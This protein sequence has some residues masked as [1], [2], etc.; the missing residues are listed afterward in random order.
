MDSLI[1]AALAEAFD[2]LGLDTKLGLSVL[3]STVDAD[4]WPHVSFLAAGDLL[5]VPPDEARLIL[6]PQATTVANLERTRQGVLFG[7]ADGAVHELRFAVTVVDAA[8]G[9][10]TIVIGR[11]DAVRT[12]R[13]PYASVESLIDF[14]LH[15]PSEVVDRWRQQVAD[16]AAMKMVR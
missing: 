4:G 15:E 12:H 13:A 7:A 6:W 8:E 16:M 11:V 5:L 1:P 9:R 14:R 3:L 2:G 10:G